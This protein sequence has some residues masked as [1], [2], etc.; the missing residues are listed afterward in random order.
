MVS[1]DD[2]SEPAQ[3]LIAGKVDF[4]EQHPVAVLE[5]FNEGS[6]NE[7]EDKSPA[8]LQFLLPLLQVFDASIKGVHLCCS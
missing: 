2:G 6:F 3:H 1:L 7:L 4:V 5:T 8:R